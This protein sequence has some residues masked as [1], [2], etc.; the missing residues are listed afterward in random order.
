M[1]L[2][3]LIHDVEAEPETDATLA[4]VLGARERVEERRQQRGRHAAAVPDLDVDAVGV[5]RDV[6]HDRGVGGAVLHGIAD[7]VAQHLRDPVAV[8]RAVGVAGLTEL[9]AAGGRRLELGEDH[10]RDFAEV[11]GGRQ[12]RDAALQ[13]GTRE[14]EQLLDETRHAA[15]RA[16]HRVGH[17]R[18]DGRIVGL[19]ENHLRAELDALERAPQIVTEDRDEHVAEAQHLFQL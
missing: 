2:H 17:A 18:R 14:I 9:D 3:D 5:A 4:A 15:R 7:E 10:L 6:D 13:T 16:L 1:R 19:A 11:A 12:D 8:P